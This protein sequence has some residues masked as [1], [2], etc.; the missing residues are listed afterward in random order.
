MRKV[1]ISPYNEQWTLMFEK[2][3]T[4]LREIFSLQ[5]VAIHHIGSTSVRGLVAKPIIDI[6]PVVKDI[7]LID[8]YNGAMEDVGY[9]P[10]GENE[11][12]GRRYFEKGGNNRTHHVHIY[13]YGSLE[14]ERHL[15]FRDYLL[16]HPDSIK[17]YGELKEQL[18][19]QFPYDIESY[20]AG[21]ERFVSDIERQA[22]EW[23]WE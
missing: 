2:E 22:V 3:A 16:T 21:K 7:T 9:E 12:S 4:K 6:M 1:E 15:A 8:E 18:A 10:K 5:I 23:Y 14:I 13:Q 17:A 20:I 11:I 19:R